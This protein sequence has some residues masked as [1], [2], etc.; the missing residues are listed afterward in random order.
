[1]RSTRG[2]PAR[3]VERRDDRVAEAPGRVRPGL[4]RR[5]EPVEEV[6]R[7]A[8]D[9]VDA[10][11]ACSCPQSMLTSALEVVEIG[12]QVGRDGC[13]QRVELG[14]RTASRRARRSG[15]PSARQSTGARVRATRLLS[16]PDRATGRDPPA[17]GT[18]RLPAGAG[19]QARGRRRPAADLV[20]PARSRAAMR[21]SSSA[22]AVPARD[23]PDGVA[24]VV[25]LDPPAAGRSRR[26][27]R[28]ASPST[29]RRTRVTGS[30][31]SRGSARSGPRRS[32]RPRSPSPSATSRRPGPR[33]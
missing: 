6:G 24:A 4:D 27:P 11:R 13:A 33:G 18:Q 20:R 9:L 28:R 7:P 14:R 17:R 8:A 21:S 1:M 12:G 23:W 2:P 3:P 22:R 15:R 25:G 32:P 10:R 26:G 31:R 29:A 5:A 30:S 19:G 16:C